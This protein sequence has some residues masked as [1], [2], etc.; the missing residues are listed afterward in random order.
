MGLLN[1]KVLTSNVDADTENIANAYMTLS[2][3][4]MRLLPRP[5]LEALCGSGWLI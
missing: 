4:M 5:Q 2:E 3:A 1:L